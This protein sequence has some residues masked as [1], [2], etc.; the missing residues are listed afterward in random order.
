MKKGLVHFYKD[1]D[2][3]A[4][5]IFDK[6]YS[7]LC[8]YNL[9]VCNISCSGADNLSLNYRKKPIPCIRISNLKMQ[10]HT[11]LKTHANY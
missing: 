10:T 8:K 1:F 2:K 11:R 7:V 9:K 4:N 3:T 5:A 6:V